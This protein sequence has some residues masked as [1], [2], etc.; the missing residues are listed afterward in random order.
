MAT[1][2]FTYSIYH[3]S[4]SYRLKTP[5]SAKVYHLLA[6]TLDL[7]IIA[8]YA[9]IAILAWRQHTQGR[10]MDWTTVFT[11]YNTDSKIVYGVFL[12]A[13]VAGGLVL[14]TL[15]MSLYLI[16][17]FRKLASL[18]PDHNPFVEDDDLQLA[19][20][21]KVR[22]RET[23][24]I[25]F[26]G[27]RKVPFVAT[28][29]LPHEQPST[30]IASVYP[31]SRRH[32]YESLKLDPSDFLESPREKQVLGVG[33]GQ[34]QADEIEVERGEPSRSSLKRGSRVMRPASIVSLPQRTSIRGGA[35][36]PVDDHDYDDDDSAL[37]VEERGRSPAEPVGGKKKTWGGAAVHGL[38]KTALLETKESGWKF[39]RFSGQGK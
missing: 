21:E 16:H 13:C 37:I 2:H 33:Y 34:V 38:S 35:F 26:L 15:S 22:W 39:R 27:G 19:A 12:V 3:L 31:E 20:S 1:V 14:A 25:P 10:M 9:Y 11:D 5:Q 24:D 23:S 29:G 17:A 7:I 28:R 4:G 36:I 8:F 18:P 30:P 32:T 6:S